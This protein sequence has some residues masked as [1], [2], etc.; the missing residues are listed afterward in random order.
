MGFH[1][2]HM[3][4]HYY[5]IIIVTYNYLGLHIIILIQLRLLTKCLW[6]VMS[7]EDD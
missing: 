5:N 3:K 4:I 1:S 7:I 2:H 6:H